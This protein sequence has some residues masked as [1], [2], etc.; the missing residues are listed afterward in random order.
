V[1][2]TTALVGF[3]MKL[4][5]NKKTLTAKQHRLRRVLKKNQNLKDAMGRDAVKDIKKY[6][7]LSN[8]GI[9]CDAMKNGKAI[10]IH[11]GNTQAHVQ[12]WGKT[13]EPF[14]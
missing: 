12:F 2:R 10:K 6:N 7:V 14:N 9:V 5:G 1:L 3:K 11:L 4:L 13:Y 8:T